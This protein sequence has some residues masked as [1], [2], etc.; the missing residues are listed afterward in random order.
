M[1]I[2]L[3]GISFVLTVVICWIVD[4]WPE[5]HIRAAFIKSSIIHGILIVLSTELLSI[6]H[7]LEFKYVFLLWSL[8]S[9]IAVTALILL[10][11]SNQRLVRLLQRLRQQYKLIKNS[12]LTA[13][14]GIVTILSLTLVTAVIAPP[15]NWDSMTYHMPRVMHWIQNHT[16]AQYPTND[17]R[18][19]S[20]PPGAGYIVTQL[21]ILCGGDRFANCVQWFAFLG[22]ILGISLITNILS[23]SQAEWIAALVCA[24]IPMA[25]MQSTTTQTDLT[26]SFWLV[27]FTY[28]IFNNNIYSISNLFWLSSS[29]GLSIL[30]KPTAFIFALPL[31]VIFGFFVFQNTLKRYKNFTKIFLRSIVLT[32][33]L[34]LLS[35][36]LSLPSYWRNYQTFGT[37]LGID[38]GTRSST[39][40]LSELTSNVLKNLALNI[41]LPGVWELINFIHINVLKININVTELNSYTSLSG[42][43]TIK[44]APLLKVLAP[45]EDLIGNPVHLAI[46]VVAFWFLIFNLRI[47]PTK[48]NKNLFLLATANI[49]GFII[50]SFLIKWKPWGNRLLLSTFILNAPVIAH[51]LISSLNRKFRNILVILIILVAVLYSLTPVR[52]PIIALPIQSPAQSKSILL[53]P[54]KDV[55]FSGSRKELELPYKTAV[56]IVKTKYNCSTVGL[57][58]KMYDWEYPFWA[59]FEENNSRLVRIKH[60]SVQN[61]SSKLKPEFPDSEM[62]AIIS[63]NNSYSE[64]ELSENRSSWKI[65]T[66]SVS[67]FVKIYVKQVGNNI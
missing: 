66:V 64:N 9:L 15:N 51:Y 48:K 20:F 7:L 54:R 1:S 45:H 28:F 41:P 26:L 42:H 32:L 49:S 44:I 58:S 10:L 33:I 56:N 47:Q 23:G 39:F 29:L 25:I 46:G 63:T 37:F 52:H 30:T 65:S 62:C 3:I 13:F 34:F 16:V 31:L 55:Y 57:A 4:D 40:G 8:N 2:L 36:S 11:Y 27:C 38:T 60:I 5:C 19:I 18:Q 24:S 12:T 14:G 17:L 53:L 50:F 59:L 43:N 67:P 35:I 6:F 22:S 61:E 21:Q